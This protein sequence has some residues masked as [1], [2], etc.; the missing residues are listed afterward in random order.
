MSVIYSNIRSTVELFRNN[1]LVFA[2]ISV[3]HLLSLAIV[4]VGL[5]Y[6]F[7]SRSNKDM[8]L[9][10]QDVSMYTPSLI[11]R[12]IIFMV[13]LMSLSVMAFYYVQSNF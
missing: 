9:A 10:N 1:P 5:I 11:I 2:T 12:N 3:S 6:I 13:L 7:T 8:A 4:I